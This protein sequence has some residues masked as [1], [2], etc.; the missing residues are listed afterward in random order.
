MLDELT[1]DELTRVCYLLNEILK[2]AAH[3][4]IA[5]IV[6][7]LDT[8][9][10]SIKKLE[11]ILELLTEMHEATHAALLAWNPDLQQYANKLNQEYQPTVE[12]LT[13]MRDT[14]VLSPWL[15]RR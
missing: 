11:H 10:F 8:S 14:I 7:E 4:D 15:Q 1:R 3:P 6:D 12:Q 9:G 13:W 2:L 5:P